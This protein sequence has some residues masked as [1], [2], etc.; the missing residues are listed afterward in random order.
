[1]F[2][3]KSS[4]YMAEDHGEPPEVRRLQA[5]AFDPSMSVRLDTAPINHLTFR[6]RWEQ[7]L[8]PG[9]VGEYLEV[10]DYDPAS[11]CW[12]EPVD[13]NAT[14]LLAQDGVAPSL[15][16]PQF[17][18]QMVY[19]VAMYTIEN[20]EQALGRQ[21]QWSPRMHSGDISHP[22]EMI[23]GEEFVEKLRLYPHALRAANAFYSPQ[24]KSILFG[25]FEGPSGTVFS[26]LSQD[27]VAHEVTHALLDGMHRRYVEDNH[28]DTLAFHEAFADLVALFQHFTFNEVLEHQIERTRG[29]LEAPSLLGELAQEF[30]RATG[31]YGAL[32]SAI[33]TVD[34]NGKWVLVKP[35]PDLLKSTTEPHP[36]GAIL[37][38]A[39]FAAFLAIY[40]ARSKPLLTLATSGS[41]VLPEGLLHPTLVKVLAAEAT[42]T[43]K[44]FL[45]MCI[46]ALDYCPPFEIN[47]G[48]YLRALI[49]ADYDMVPLDNHGYRVALIESFRNWG[50]VPE[51]VRTISEEQLRWGFA[52]NAF[53]NLHEGQWN[54]L[55][56][57][58]KELAPV[59]N[60]TLYRTSRADQAR[61]LLEARVQAH[62]F[63]QKALQQDT[64]SSRRDSFMEITGL[65][66]RPNMNV[67]GLRY[68]RNSLPSFEVHAVIPTLRVTPDGKIMKQLIITVT[69]RIRGVPID[70]SKEVDPDAKGDD[71]FDFRGG[72]TLIFDMESEEPRL[73]YAITRN[74]HDSLRLDRVRRHRRQRS[75][76][77]LSLRET[78]FAGQP[79]SQRSEPFCLLHGEH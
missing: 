41:G 74:I 42:K 63:L 62:A 28:L 9:P 78:Y 76:E 21:I 52:K 79:Q 66:V 24:K 48:D 30:G 31:R 61:T 64:N 6:I 8:Q 38:A 57:L 49:T 33:G 1:M 56:E 35:D 25:Y 73:R 5:F 46:R 12:Y 4:A 54:A 60:K 71:R 53:K 14:F 72:T 43:A 17:H 44:H 7:G 10:V 2:L 34:Q 13:L 37:V 15:G 70:E 40:K 55:S 11:G 47:F 36:R 22:Q 75:E 23:S 58:A 45:Q 77:G 29:D 50:I 51:G 32:R 26:C 69:Q 16:N 3:E 18:Q 20:F 19:T 67:P 27:I 68:K 59:I 65:D 39:V